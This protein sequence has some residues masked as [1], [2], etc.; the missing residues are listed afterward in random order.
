MSRNECTTPPPD[1]TPFFLGGVEWS[2]VES[3]RALDFIGFSAFDSTPLGN[4]NF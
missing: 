2:R 3:P 1:S 4:H